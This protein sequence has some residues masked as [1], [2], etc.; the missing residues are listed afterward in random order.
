MAI[1]LL[2]YP[3][4]PPLILV[5]SRCVLLLFE[6]FFIDVFSHM[7]FLKLSLLCELFVVIFLQTSSRHTKNTRKETGYDDDDDDE[8]GSGIIIRL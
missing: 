8:I 2:E 4:K 1:P 5:V 3:K 7:F 6:L